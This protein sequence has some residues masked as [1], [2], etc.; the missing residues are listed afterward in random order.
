MGFIGCIEKSQFVGIQTAYKTGFGL[1]T[2]YD[3]LT[4]MA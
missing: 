1:T 2:F 3:S 4:I